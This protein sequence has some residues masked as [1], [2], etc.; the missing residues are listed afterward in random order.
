ML[1]RT[2]ATINLNDYSCTFGFNCGD[3]I[4]SNVKNICKSCF[5]DIS[6]VMR[7]PGQICFGFEIRKK[8]NRTVFQLCFLKSCSES[9]MKP[10]FLRK[11]SGKGITALTE[12]FIH[13]FKEI[14]CLFI[15][16]KLFCF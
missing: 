13:A 14:L 16:Q 2:C 15:Q 7:Y 8:P 4:A 5:L 10:H 6:N 12:T 1:I 9:T 11:I 3:E